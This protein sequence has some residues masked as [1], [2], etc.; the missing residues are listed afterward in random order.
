MSSTNPGRRRGSIARRVSLAGGL[1]LAIVLAAA[2]GVQSVM[3]IRDATRIDVERFGERAEAVAALAAAFDDAARTMAEKFYNAFAGTVPAPYA[4]DGGAL[5]SAGV[6]LDGNVDA[7]DRFAAMTGG[8][9]TVFALRGDEFVR[10][11]TSVKKEDGTRAVGTALAR[12]H[13]AHAAL[14]DGRP[15]VG[16]PCSAGPT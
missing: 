11:T 13:P 9:A 1:G 15:Y 10:V 2:A 12:E 7:V 14:T 8:T 4:L 3:S 5:S 16:P 6:A